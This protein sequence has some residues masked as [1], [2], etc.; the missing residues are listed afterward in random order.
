MFRPI[1]LE[2]KATL[3][4]YLKPANKQCCDYAFANLYAWGSFYRTVWCEV[5]GFLIFRFQIAGSSKW[6]YLEPIGEG[7]ISKAIAFIQNDA[8][9]A[10]QQPIRFFSLSKEFVNKAKNIPALQSQRFY[11]NRSF[12]NYI[13]SREKLAQLSGKKF[14]G[15]RNHIAQFDKLYPTA[16]WKVIDPQTDLSAVYALLENWITSQGTPTTTILQE[17]AMIEKSLAAYEALELFGI[18]LTV[19]G[20]NVAFAYGSRV[21]ANTFCIH[22]EKADTHYE[23]SYAKINQ[24]LAQNLP[25]EIQY[26]NREEDMG[27]ESLRKAKLSYYP[28]ILTE[29]YFSY[30]T[31][32]AEAQIWKLWQT[33]FPEDDDA[34]MPTFLYPYSEDASRIT[35]YQ[36]GKLASMLHLIAGENDWGKIGYIYGLATDP[37]F[38]NQGLAKQ[39][40]EKAIASASA[41]GFVAICAI[42]ENRNYHVWQ[43][44][45]DFSE[46]QSEPLRFL[47]EDGFDFGSDPENDFG[48]F[49]IINMQAY[50]SLYAKEHPELCTEISIE[51]PLLPGNSGTYSFLEGFVTHHTRKIANKSSKPAEI[52]KNFP[53][54]DKKLLKIAVVSRQH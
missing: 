7:D 18:L 40:I 25:S 23:G 38:R 14:H 42:Q 16:T 31:R 15:K 12:G 39:A 47:S 8:A 2:S 43:T 46:P 21:N 20:K 41:Q 37:E 26:I 32:S 22:A 28:D 24:L 10:T 53:I 4:R 45:L 48:I 5:E 1:D 27:L 33:C 19:D 36:N 34:F 49:R 52:F 3:E 17:K 11:K 13:Y 35:L 30:D 50:L 9:T 44:Q 6:A 29:E 54:P 51:D